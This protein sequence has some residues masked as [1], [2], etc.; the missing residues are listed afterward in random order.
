MV[1]VTVL[2]AVSITDTVPARVGDVDAVA[3]GADG[4]PDRTVADGDGG[5]GFELEGL[6]RRGDGD[7]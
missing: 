7:H 2:V 6:V 5:G 3:V 1:A 4:H